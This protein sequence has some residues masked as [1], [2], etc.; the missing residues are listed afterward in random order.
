MLLGYAS[1]LHTHQFLVYISGTY[2]THGC[3]DAGE[4]TRLY[5]G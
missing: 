5:N 2:E 3:R 1:D 4:V